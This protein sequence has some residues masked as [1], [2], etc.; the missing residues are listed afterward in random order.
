M[1]LHPNR[2][3]ADDRENYQNTARTIV[4]DMNRRR[5]F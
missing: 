2:G 4:L 3:I 5:Y 1:K